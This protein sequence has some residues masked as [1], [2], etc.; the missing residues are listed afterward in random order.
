MKDGASVATTP[1][2]EP[3]NPVKGSEQEIS[4]KHPEMSCSTAG[5]TSDQNRSLRESRM[6]V[7]R[8]QRASMPATVHPQS[9]WIFAHGNRCKKS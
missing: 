4:E 3:L 1:Y 7:S 9:R 2:S 8:K 5:S 6:V